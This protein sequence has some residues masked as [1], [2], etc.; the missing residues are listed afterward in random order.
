[1]DIISIRCSRA[2]QCHPKPVTT[3]FTEY[4]TYSAPWNRKW[5][6]VSDRER[7]QRPERGK[8]AFGVD[9]SVLC[10]PKHIAK[11]QIVMLLS[12][13]VLKKYSPANGI[14]LLRKFIIL[15]HLILYDNDTESLLLLVGNERPSAAREKR[16]PR[17]TRENIIINHGKSNRESICSSFA[18][19][20]WRCIARPKRKVPLS[21]RRVGEIRR[22][23]ENAWKMMS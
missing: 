19:E 7:R 1:M 17:E 9:F 8:N 3:E 15:F 14:N 5:A 20:W 11:Y 18:R 23:Q 10:Q 4:R 6:R 13:Y 2:R 16:K 22:K 12:V 21:E